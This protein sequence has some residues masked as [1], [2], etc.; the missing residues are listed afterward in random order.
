VDL[1][2]TPS[3]VALDSTGRPW[4]AVYHRERRPQDLTLWHHDGTAWRSRRV[5]SEVARAFPGYEHASVNTMT[6]DARGRLYLACVI[7]RQGEDH[8]GAKDGWGEPGDRVVLLTSDDQGGTFDVVPLSGVDP[9][10]PNLLATIERPF[11]PRPIDVPSLVYTH[12]GSGVSNQLD[13]ASTEVVF[14][15]LGES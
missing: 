7:Q 10:R 4:L 11:G 12:G 1:Q 2:V 6:F 13:R 5:S 15:C 14:V 3:N 8:G 9:V